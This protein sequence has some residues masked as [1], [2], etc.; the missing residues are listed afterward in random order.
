MRWGLTRYQNSR[1]SHFVTFCCYHRSIRLL[2]CCRIHDDGPPTSG[3]YS[4]LIV[5][6]FFP[7][8][9][10]DPARQFMQNETPRFDTGDRDNSAN[11][12]GVSAPVKGG[13]PASNAASS[14]PFDPEAT[15]VDLALSSIDQLARAKPDPRSTGAGA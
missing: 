13:S 6:G 8:I 11:A 15:L 10:L 5:G 4:E 2:R 3:I 9:C 12:Q 1:R 7:A 14:A